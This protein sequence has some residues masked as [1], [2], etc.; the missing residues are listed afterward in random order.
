MNTVR[1]S[2]PQLEQLVP[3]DPKYLPA[4]IMNSANENPQDVEEQIK[5]EAMSAVRNVKLNRYPD[6]L[7]NE[8][9]DLIAEAN[10]LDRN[11]VLLGNGGDELLFN[12]ALAYGGPGRKFLNMPPTFSVYQN[13]AQLTGTEVVNVP[14][15]VD[16]SIDEQAV[17]DRVS[18]GDIDFV[19]VTS[20]NN[21]TGQL[22]PEDFVLKLLDA[23]DALVMVDEAYFEFSRTTLR[24]YLMQ[25]QNLVLLRTFSKAFSL[26][27]VRLGYLLGNECVIREFLK[28]RQPYSVDAV[29][30]A[31]GK[32][33]FQN[34]AKFEPG[35]IQIISER[36]R[37]LE[38][39]A[40]IPGVDPYPSDS[41][42]ILFKVAQAGQVWQ[43]LFDQGILI[44]DF[45][46]ARYLEGSLRVSVGTPQENDQFL[47]ALRQI[48][49]A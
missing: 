47:A 1:K 33:V 28:V 3:Y 4:K 9:R 44:R 2:A 43:Q 40:A 16:Y 42:Y 48:V 37:M 12:L 20:P 23:T 39:L 31:I 35:I 27:G 46:K 15:L 24:P 10:G 11:Q 18:Q 5:R 7:A 25:H 30:Q 22:A 41:N 8:L 17:L 38:E 49:T 13:N 45:S 32:V 34:R 21:P 29:S 36:Q 26:A 6:P 14:R 19:I